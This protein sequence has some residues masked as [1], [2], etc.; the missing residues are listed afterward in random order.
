MGIAEGLGLVQGPGQPDPIDRLLDPFVLSSDVRLARADRT[1]ICAPGP[2][3]SAPPAG[4]GVD[5][6]RPSIL[7]GGFDL[8][9][10]RGPSEHRAV[11]ALRSARTPVG[12]AAV[13]AWEIRRGIPR[14]PD[15]FGRDALPAE[16]N[17]GAPIIDEAK[18]CFLGQESV[19]KVRNLGHPPHVILPLRADGGMAIGDVVLAGDAECG[20]VTAATPLPVRGFAALARVRWSARGGPLV[21]RSGVVLVPR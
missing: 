18:G 1:L 4:H 3:P 20:T 21:T 9:A 6:A 8:L 14:F 5:V 2:G 10:V 15:D 13:R 19:A 12:E 17:L 11:E 16:G 7:G